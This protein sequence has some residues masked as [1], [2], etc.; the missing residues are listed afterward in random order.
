MTTHIPR[1]KA[2]DQQLNEPEQNSLY[3]GNH[4]NSANAP[5]TQAHLKSA[6][7]ESIPKLRPSKYSSHT[8][9]HRLLRTV[10]PTVLIPLAIASTVSYGIFQKRAESEIKIQLQD[11]ALLAGQSALQLRS[12]GLKFAQMV[13]SNPLVID[14]ARA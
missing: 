6:S 10:L 1:P 2:Y 13:A 9:S 7:S 4:N 11:Q 14:A 8:L 5:N 12:D 3:L